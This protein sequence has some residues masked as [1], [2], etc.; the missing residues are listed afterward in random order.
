[1]AIFTII[2]GL[3]CL[4]FAWLIILAEGLR[5]LPK[6]HLFSP[7]SQA[8]V[9]WNQVTLNVCFVPDRWSVEHQE[10][11]SWVSEVRAV[12]HWS[13]EK[14]Q[15]S[16]NGGYGEGAE[17]LSGSFHI[18]WALAGEWHLHWCCIQPNNAFVY[19]DDSFKNNM[20]FCMLQYLESQLNI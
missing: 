12:D 15:S 14:V 4:P 1:M 6:M 8:H 11:K 5:Q 18:H 2:W 16:P 9:A 20:V 13:A 7:Q 17:D 19:V 3:L 10:S